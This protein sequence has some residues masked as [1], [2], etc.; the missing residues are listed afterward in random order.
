MQFETYIR[1]AYFGIP[2]VTRIY[3]TACIFTTLIMDLNLVNPF[4]LYFNLN[5]IQNG[6][7]WR[8][9]TTFLYFGKFEPWFFIRMYC[10]C[11]ESGHFENHLFLGRTSN[12]V[13]FY[14][15][16]FAFITAIVTIS[17]K[18]FQ[19]FYL[20]YLSMYIFYH[21]NMHTYTLKTLRFV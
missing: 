21:L 3:I 6:E 15:F 5:L 17:T 11:N 20:F 13:K 9:F 18:I 2:P 16:A 19:R 14:G 1:Q 4:K 8:L 12:F 7:I 10:L